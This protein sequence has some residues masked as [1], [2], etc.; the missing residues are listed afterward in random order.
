MNT[1]LVLALLSA[2]PP[3][4]PTLPQAPAAPVTCGQSNC[5]CGCRDDKT[6]RCG[7]PDADGWR[8]DAGRKVYWRWVPS[9]AIPPTVTQPSASVPMF[10]Q[11]QTFH[12]PSTRTFF[13]GRGFQRGGGGGSC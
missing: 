13:G 7:K 4:A 9:Q 3:Q 1:L 11:P 8:W 12:T 10:L 6:C 2:R 5:P